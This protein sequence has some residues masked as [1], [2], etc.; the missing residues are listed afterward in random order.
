MIAFVFGDEKSPKPRPRIISTM[1]MYQ[2]G[3]VSERKIKRKSPSAVNPIPTDEM[4]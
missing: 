1:T 4:I 2:S 3:V